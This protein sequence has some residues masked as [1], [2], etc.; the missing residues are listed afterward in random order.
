[1]KNIRLDS[2]TGEFKQT[3]K[4]FMPILFKLFRKMEEGRN[5]QI[6]F[7]KNTTIQ[8]NHRSTSLMKITIKI[9][10]KVLTN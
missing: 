1:M 6:Y 7:M 10:N 2:F 3:Y 4:E 5:F 9:L 8:E